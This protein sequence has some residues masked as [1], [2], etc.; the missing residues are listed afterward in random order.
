MSFPRRVPS[1][2]LLSSLRTSSS[3]SQFCLRAPATKLR[4]ASTEQNPG[5]GP[6]FKGQLYEST[7]ARLMKERAERERYSK[8]RNESSGGKNSALTFGA[9]IYSWGV[10]G[11]LGT[12]DESTVQLSYR[13]LSEDTISARSETPVHLLLRLPLFRP[14]NLSSII[15]PVQ[16]SKPHGRTL[17][18]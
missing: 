13:Q 2:A 3:L 18:K 6:S 17:S 9:Q 11:R 1:A 5:E 14:P 8:N 7:Q 15:H 4:Y 16:I 10:N 12:A